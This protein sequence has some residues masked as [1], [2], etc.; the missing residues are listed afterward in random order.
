[1]NN[2]S[3][4][5]W[6]NQEL[7]SQGFGFI[8]Q[9]SIVRKMPWSIVTALHT[10][11]G[12]L[13][14]KQMIPVFAIEPAILQ[15][16]SHN[17]SNQVPKIIATNKELSCFIMEEAGQPLRNFQKENSY[18]EKLFEAL[19]IYATIQIKCISHVPLLLQMNLNDWRLRKIPALYQEFM[20]QE[21]MLK[22]D[23]LALAE[24]KSLQ[25]LLP[26]IEMLCKKLSTHD[27]PETLEHC[28]FHDNNIL[29]QDDRITIND[30]GDA[31]ITHPFFS[32]A[33]IL[34]SSQRSY[35]LQETDD[36]Y[37]QIKCVYLEHWRDYGS[38]DKLNEAF[39]IAKVLHKFIFALSFSRIESCVDNNPHPFKGYLTTSL[40]QLLT[41]ISR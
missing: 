27:I 3:V 35:N 20:Q 31:C 26:T 4:L 11:K 22:K 12:Q 30:W 33:S 13:Y 37:E 9:H 24:I 40:K 28:D 8:I 41:E 19:R 25:Q 21:D 14:L 10:I 2:P 6:A 36:M 29:A 16:L 7:E 23:G 38:M 17:I 39:A 1:M 32:L 15:F 18:S 34:S 5:V